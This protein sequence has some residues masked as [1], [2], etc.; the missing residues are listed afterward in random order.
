MSAEGSGPPGA[1]NGDSTLQI[2]HSP[3][4]IQHLTFHTPHST[5]NIQHSPLNIQHSTLN[6]QHF[7]IS[8][9]SRMMFEDLFS[10]RLVVEMRVYLRGTDV[11]MSEEH[12]YDS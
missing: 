8:Y 5:L 9:V 1:V 3:F 12:L 10:Q 7:I 4:N 2:P 11:G 6:I